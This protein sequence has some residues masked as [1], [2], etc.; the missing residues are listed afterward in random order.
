MDARTAWTLLEPLHG[1]V[2][3]APERVAA[4]EAEGLTGGWAGYFASRSAALGAVAPE[5]VIATF[6]VFG[7]RRVRRT[8]ADVWVGT[9]P[10]ALLAA[11]GG[12]ARSVLKRTLGG[13]PETA[14]AAELL[15]PV[16]ESADPG[17]RALFAAHSALPWPDSPAQALWHA[18]TLL[19]EHRGDG[20]VAALVAAGV[21]GCEA[22]VLAAAAGVVDE[23]HPRARGW[24]EEETAAATGRLRERGHLDADGGLTRAGRELRAAVE[25]ATDLAAAPP[26]RTLGAAASAELEGLLGLLLERYLAGF[27]Y[28]Y[29]NPVG[30]PRAV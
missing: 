11:R 13:A 5:V 29:P 8:L 15:R 4:Y 30:V 10:E 17:G 27:P 12:V 18:A 28:P 24:T 16:A 6:H 7:P 21:D 23:D 14:R 2:Y 1:C 19:R 20:H 9:T 26:Y 25:D 3:F 22:T